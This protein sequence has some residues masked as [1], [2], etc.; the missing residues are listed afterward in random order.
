[1][2]R[3]YYLNARNHYLVDINNSQ[4]TSKHNR[5]NL[6]IVFLVLAVCFHNKSYRSLKA[7]SFLV[8]GIMI[9]KEDFYHNFFSYFWQISNMLIVQFIFITYQMWFIHSLVRTDNSVAINF[10]LETHAD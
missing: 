6:H 9:S 10:T 7:S 3:L 8:Q 1:M 5:G 2:L 4:S